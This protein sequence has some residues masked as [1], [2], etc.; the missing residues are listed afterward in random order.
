M[1]CSLEV[2]RDRKFPTELLS[3]EDGDEAGHGRANSRLWTIFS[4]PSSHAMRFPLLTKIAY[5]DKTG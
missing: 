4:L 5:S 1:V 3:S 2:D